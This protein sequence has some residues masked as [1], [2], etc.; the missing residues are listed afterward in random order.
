MS[1]DNSFH[2]PPRPG[3]G[4]LPAK[5]P[6]RD[7]NWFGP[8]CEPQEEFIQ[9]FPELRA[10]QPPPPPPPRA[11]PQEASENDRATRA[12]DETDRSV[13]KEVLIPENASNAAETAASASATEAPNSQRPTSDPI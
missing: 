6:W 10:P 4:T 5:C 3:D 12:L 13:I 7:A 11:R 2:Y 1:K 8:S 9:E